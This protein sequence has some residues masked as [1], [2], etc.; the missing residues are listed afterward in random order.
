MQG[1]G[2]AS[3]TSNLDSMGEFDPTDVIRRFSP[4][5]ASAKAKH[6]ELNFLSTDNVIGVS[7]AEYGEWSEIEI[8]LHCRFIHRDSIVIDVGANIG[9][10]TLAYCRKA[11]GGR[12]IF[13]EPQP[14]M[15]SL[16]SKSVGDND[17]SNAVG[18]CA[19]LSD[20]IGTGYV[21][22]P[23][24]GEGG[25]FGMVKLSEVSE[26]QAVLN[27][28]QMITI[29]S[30]GLDRCDFIK[31]DAEGGT[32]SILKG[33]AG[34]I[35]KHSPVIATELLGVE[36]GWLI[37]Q[38]LALISPAYVVYFYRFTAFN[39][40]NHNKNYINR[41]GAAEECGIIF[42]TERI[43]VECLPDGLYVSE[44]SSLDGLAQ[45]FLRTS[46]YG[47]YT[48]FDR[49]PETIGRLYIDLLRHVVPAFGNSIR[50]DQVDFSTLISVDHASQLLWDRSRTDRAADNQPIVPDDVT[51]RQH[52]AML[53]WERRL[54]E[55]AISLDERETALAA[56][57]AALCAHS[58][59]IE[60]R[61]LALQQWQETLAEQEN[62]L[63]KLEEV[64]ADREHRVDGR[65]K[66]LR[67]LADQ[68]A[69]QRS[70]GSEQEQC[71]DEKR[72]R[73]QQEWSDIEVERRNLLRLADKVR[74]EALGD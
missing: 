49:K 46:K 16:L 51:S 34:T 70:L 72:K 50:S 6:G 69:V 10:H 29:D 26:T 54:H 65:E 39:K 44:I 52:K 55:H 56:Q 43:S 71:L 60:N 24:Y 4:L 74:K 41:F 27:N 21:D 62:E 1:A 48:P 32:V 19:A 68:M 12:V 66:S 17:L 45:E 67:A 58:I 30:L 3:M 73:I 23:D 22:F 42:S 13:F 11:W 37:M 57:S 18:Y 31:I 14:I 47:D 35:E 38:Q 59:G 7:I 2:N 64:I 5:L 36:D 33:A 25:N 9:S 40:N 53:N 8:D 20:T 61:K 63:R 15:F 28:V